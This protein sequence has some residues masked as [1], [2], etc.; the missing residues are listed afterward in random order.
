VPFGVAALG[1]QG[2]WHI[3]GINGI[4]RLRSAAHRTKRADLELNRKD[5]TYLS[6][7]HVGTLEA[8]WNT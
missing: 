1:M 2:R 8:K 7:S 4:L 5:I 6:L 3:V